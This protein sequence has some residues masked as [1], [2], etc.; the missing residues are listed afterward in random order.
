MLTHR[1]GS[2]WGHR[3]VWR[4]LLR[5]AFMRP[6]LRP[7]RSKTRAS[8]GRTA[9]MRRSGKSGSLSLPMVRCSYPLQLLPFRLH[10]III[11]NCCSN[12]FSSCRGFLITVLHPPR[13]CSELD[14]RRFGVSPVAVLATSFCL[15]H[16]HT[17][18]LSSMHDTHT[19]NGRFVDEWRWR[20]GWWHCWP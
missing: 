6:R 4:R 10:R 2:V 9:T 5:V 8:G 20:L 19:E 1:R 17:T 11:Y 13:V 15:L 18:Q 3:R 12:E 14:R 7:P 16:T